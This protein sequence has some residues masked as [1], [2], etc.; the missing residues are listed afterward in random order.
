MS[1]LNDKC[2]K[3]ENEILLEHGRPLRFG[4]VDGPRGVRMNGVRQEVVSLSECDESEL[5]AHD[6]TNAAGAFMLSRL[7][8]P[9]DPVPIGV[10]LD[11]ERPTY[12]ETIMEQERR[13]VASAGEGGLQRLLSGPQ[14]WTVA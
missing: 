3:V 5:Y 9:N 6:E 11:V 2:A 8:P 1:A 13:A 4:P 12:E 14:T 10:F 7:E